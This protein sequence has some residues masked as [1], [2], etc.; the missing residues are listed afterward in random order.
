M[1]LNEKLQTELNCFSV[2]QRHFVIIIM[3]IRFQFT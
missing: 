3:K 1:E 2:W